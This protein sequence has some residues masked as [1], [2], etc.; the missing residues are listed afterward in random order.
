MPATARG[1]ETTVEALSAMSV[2][3]QMRYVARYFK[4]YALFIETLEDMYMSILM[5]RYI[6]CG[7]DEVVFEDGTVAY[8]QNSGFDKDKDGRITVREITEKIREWHV[9][10]L[11]AGNFVEV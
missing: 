1:L 5:P 10:G 9:R 7:L 2:M 3:E 6:G 11:S 8:Q 4:A